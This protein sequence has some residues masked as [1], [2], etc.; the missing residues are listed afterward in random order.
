[1]KWELKE[2]T[3]NHSD[4]NTKTNLIEKCRK[5][6]KKNLFKSHIEHRRRQK[7]IKWLFELSAK[8]FVMGEGAE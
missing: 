1:M 8:I 5:K 3:G 6:N 4:L 2:V 7:N